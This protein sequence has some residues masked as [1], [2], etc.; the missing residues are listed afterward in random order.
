[1]SK[2]KNEDKFK[3][4][5]KKDENFNENVAIVDL[6]TIV[7]LLVLVAIIIGIYIYAYKNENKNKDKN[8]VVLNTE[9]SVENNNSNDFDSETA[10]KLVDKYL[11]E[12]A[13]AISSPKSY[14]QKLG[15][16]TNKK[17]D[18]YSKN[19]D[20]TIIKT[21]I[22]Y[23]DIRNIMQQYI[24]K[25][26]FTKEFKGIFEASNGVTHVSNK[27]ES[28][29]TYKIVRYEEKKVNNKPVLTIWYILTENGNQSEELSMDVEFSNI[30]GSWIISD[31]R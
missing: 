9:L 21:D 22:L 14:L 30:Q 16:A 10:K 15:L 4:D 25:E 2:N 1:M 3:N 24:T 6:K 8:K 7:V 20:E 23:E 27:T 17:F 28:K 13:I 19:D 5:N 18:S 12:R 11:S 26:F 29:K 31:I